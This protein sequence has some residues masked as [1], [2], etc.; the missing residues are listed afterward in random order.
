MYYTRNNIDTNINKGNLMCIDTFSM[1][2][3]ALHF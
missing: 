1:G 2:V 3:L